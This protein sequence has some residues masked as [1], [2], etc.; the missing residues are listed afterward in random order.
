MTVITTAAARRSARTI[1]LGGVAFWVLSNIF[2]SAEAQTLGAGLSAAGGAPAKPV[3]TEPANVQPLD[4][5]VVT[6]RRRSENLLTV[7]LSV[8]AFTAKSIEQ[9]RHHQSDRR[10]GLHPQ[11]QHHRSQRL[12][13]RPTEPE[14]HHPGHD[15]QQS[16][17][18]RVGVHRRRAGELR[19]GHR[20]RRSLA[21]GGAEG[22]TERLLWPPDLRRGDQPRHP[23]AQQ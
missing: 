5:V 22:A 21:P 17:L 11:P 13:R 6:A 16:R 19:A 14:H 2:G 23:Y 4:E 9:A 10:G 7:P 20:N 3:S 15:A 12:A 1:L 8:T 18:E